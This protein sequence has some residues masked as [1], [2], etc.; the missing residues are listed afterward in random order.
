ME[1][2]SKYRPLPKGIMNVVEDNVCMFKGSLP[3][4]I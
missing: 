1:A 2:Y 4:S 3:F